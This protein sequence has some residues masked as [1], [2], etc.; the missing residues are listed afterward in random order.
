MGKKIPFAVCFG[1]YE[2]G[3]VSQFALLGR[4]AILCKHLYKLLDDIES[5]LHVREE[6]I[7]VARMV[8]LHAP[9]TKDVQVETRVLEVPDAGQGARHGEWLAAAVDLVPR[10][11][12]DLEAVGL[13]VAGN[14]VHVL[15]GKLDLQLALAVD[16]R[17]EV[18]SGL[19]APRRE[20][21]D[22]GVD[23]LDP[24]LQLCDD[25]LAVV[26]RG[27]ADVSADG[28]LARDDVD[29]PGRSLPARGLHA[30]A[31]GKL[32]EP[33]VVRGGV[34]LVEAS[35][36]LRQRIHCELHAVD[37]LAGPPAVEEAPRG[38]ELPHHHSACPQAWLAVC[39]VHP[40]HGA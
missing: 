37:G 16:V 36:E 39:R 23:V 21:V 27:E 17:P 6:G 29:G 14:A 10:S 20:F 34:L 24:F 18:V 25:V 28:A 8:N 30:A 33:V 5:V 19:W 38:L 15:L 35:L 22:V 26:P 31:A 7:L 3:A 1:H 12:H 2:N 11:A 9:E 13:H 40:V 32:V 4:I